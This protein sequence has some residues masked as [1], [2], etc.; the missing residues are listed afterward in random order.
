M[1]ACARACR[2]CERSCREMVRSMKAETK[3]G[4]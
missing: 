2:D 3:V 4:A 1:A